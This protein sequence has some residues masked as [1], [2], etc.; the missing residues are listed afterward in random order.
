MEVG[1]RKFSLHLIWH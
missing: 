1:L